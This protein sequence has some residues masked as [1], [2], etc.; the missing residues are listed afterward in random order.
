MTKHSFLSVSDVKFDFNSEDMGG[1]GGFA[2]SDAAEAAN[3]GGGAASLN[4]NNVVI[5]KKE[6]D[7]VGMFEYKGD[8]LQQVLKALIY[9]LKAK[10]AAQMLPGLPAYILF[11]MIRLVGLFDT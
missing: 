2:A 10:T 9:D 5:C 4:N 6:H 3:A 1:K 11:M 7:Y 8:Q